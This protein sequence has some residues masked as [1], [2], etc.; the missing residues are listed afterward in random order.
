MSRACT[1]LL[2]ETRYTYNACAFL[3]ASNYGLHT[4]RERE[5]GNKH[6]N[7]ANDRKIISKSLSMGKGFGEE[8]AL[9]RSV[10]YFDP[11]QLVFT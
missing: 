4:R 9:F 2:H 7:G 5:G 3:L 1:T 8:A 6:R 11:H 10:R